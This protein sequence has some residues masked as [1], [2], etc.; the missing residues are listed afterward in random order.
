MSSGSLSLHGA[1]QILRPPAEGL[2][3]L[4]GDD[5]SGQTLQPGDL[6]V[7]DGLIAGVG[8]DRGAEIVVDARGCTVVPGF[9]DCHTHLPFAGWREGEYEQKLEGV[10]YESISR[11]GGGIAASARALAESSDEA[12]LAQACQ[13]AAEM[14]AAGTTTIETKSGYGLSRDGELRALRLARELET[15]VPQT[16]LSTGLLAHAVPPGFTSD[17]W[18]AEVEAMMP[19]VLATGGVSALDIFVESIAFENRHLERMGALAAAGGLALRA[20]VEQF[21]SHRSVP[22][23][24]AAGARS[25]DHLSMLSPQD[26]P[27]LATAAC[28]AVLLP[29]AEFMGAEHRAPGRA[30]LDAGALVVLA[31]DANPGTAP[32]VS[33]PL[34]IGLGARLYKMNVRETLA[35]VTLNAAWTLGLERS[36]GSIEP[37]KQADLLLLDGPVGRIAYRLGRNPVL[38]AFIAG[39]PVYVRDAAAAARITRR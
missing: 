31:T 28:A 18:M 34:V 38:A 20:H 26:I 12:V 25:V 14:L 15:L 3:W 7:R 16:T 2:P 13:L 39:E 24:L 9:V 37:G 36:R 11:R 19:E 32:A 21:A 1:E 10:P 23:A 27:V 6:V 29:V 8:R 17:E 22:V 5:I 30:L 35:A 4:R 33:I